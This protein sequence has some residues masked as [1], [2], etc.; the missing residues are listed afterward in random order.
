MSSGGTSGQQVQNTS[1]NSV[2]GPSPVI[3]PKLEALEGDLW[4]YW[5][6]HAN[7]PGYFP[8]GTVAPQG[9]RTASANTALWQRGAAG[10]SLTAPAYG[11]VNDTLAGKYLD[12]DG[13]PWFQ[14]ALAASF[15][16]Q[17]EQLR[18]I[19]L[20]GLDARFSG[21]GR[22][23]S[24]N[25]LDTS[26]RAIKDLEQTQADAAA[27]A[28]AG[29][30]QGER[31]NQAAAAGLLPGLQ[32]MDFQNLDA[33]QR[34]GMLD[35]AHAQRLL[36]D[37]NS[38]YAYETTA[39]PNWI[40]DFASRILAAYPGGQTS[41]SGTTTS[42][43]QSSSHPSGLDTFMSLARLGLQAAPMF[44]LSDARLKDV[45]GRVGA[46]DE[47]LPLY[48]YRFKGDDQPR[49]GPMAQQVAAMRPEAVR[50]HPSGYLM[51]DYRKA[52]PPGGLL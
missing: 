29:V 3:A 44:G 5:A 38:R 32:A 47:G 27:Q 13:N 48:L 15:R 52:T 2:N 11:F 41:S 50:R 37:A 24:G 7:A 18:D 6:D 34:A 40:S 43:S 31:A 19:T 28:A 8:G 39:Q 26:L 36:D 16:P 42:S 21:A 45:A 25:H 49:I 12:V 14:K 17:T 20:P 22:Y 23:G 10:P 35:D 1:N 51:V 46:T 4:K 9:E 30:Y 33:L